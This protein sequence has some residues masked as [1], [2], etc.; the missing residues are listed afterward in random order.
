MTRCALQVPSIVQR[1]ALRA[2]HRPGF[3]LLT[4]ETPHVGTAWRSRRTNVH[5]P[6][7]FPLRAG[8]AV[9]S[10]LETIL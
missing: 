1:V 8:L 7:V 3:I 9:C 5:A 6:M 4:S 2:S 10:V